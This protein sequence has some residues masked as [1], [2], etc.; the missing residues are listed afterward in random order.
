[1]FCATIEQ[2]TTTAKDAPAE[3]AVPAT[4]ALAAESDWP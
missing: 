2:G 4:A 1:M 3:K